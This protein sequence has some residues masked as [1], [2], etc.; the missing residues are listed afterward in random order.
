M[1]DLAGLTV[2]VTRPAHQ[3]QGLCEK[4]AAAGGE[5]IAYPVI[6]IQP[7]TD[8]K[9]LQT[10]LT[11]L[12]NFDLAIFVSAN[13][14]LEIAKYLD[15]HK[16]WPENLPIAC[17]GQA[18]A[19]SL[20]QQGRQADIIAPP[21]HNSETLLTTTEFQN[22][23][24]KR[25]IIFRGEGGRELLAETLHERGAQVDYAECYRRGIPTV[26]I[27]PLQNAWQENKALVFVVT[28]NE[29]L[30]NLYTMLQKQVA[31]KLL[32]SRLVVVSERAV[33]LAEEFGFTHKALCATAASEEAILEA[34]QSLVAGDSE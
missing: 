32:K 4:I 3:A 20:K 19:R 21:P 16:A 1:P 8:I 34:L 5:A 24:G 25:V 13:A 23:Q 30:Q 29:G 12:A 14:V 33:Q 9:K 15:L 18:T 7:P 11:G 10:Q 28:S 27:A 17:V 31:R 26:N 2:V 6:E 22:V